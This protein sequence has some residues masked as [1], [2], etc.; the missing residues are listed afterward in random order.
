MVSDG[1]GGTDTATITIIV[2]SVSDVPEGVSDLYIMFS[3]EVLNVPAPGLLGNDS[4]GDGDSLTAGTGSNPAN[5]TATVN[6]DGSFTYTPNLDF[7]GEDTF[8]YSI[9]D[10]TG[11]QSGAFVTIQVNRPGNHQPV[12]NDDT[13]TT[14]EETPVTIDILANDSDPDGD[15]L[16]IIEIFGGG[17]VELNADNTITFYP[18]I[19]FNGTALIR[20]VVDDGNG[21][22]DR[23]DVRVTVNNV[24]DVPV[25]NG[26]AYNTGV[27]TPLSVAA[28]GVVGNDFDLENDI[29]SPVLADNVDFGALTLNSD[30]SFTYTPN[31]DFS[32]TDSFTYMANDG[33]D[34]SNEATVTINVGAG[35]NN[36][37]VANDDNYPTFVN[38]AIDLPAQG[39]ILANDAVGEPLIVSPLPAGVGEGSGVRGAS[40]PTTSRTTLTPTSIR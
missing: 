15:P 1:N 6:A 38:Q 40:S 33:S 11:E 34:N 20:Y 13:A 14:D 25:A 16:T 3:N 21:G 22:E 31:T 5:G 23:A 9:T 35:S 26:E 37:P 39:G 28:P 10:S 24:N 30:G 19:D 12:A 36:A 7:V 17:F 18:D 2:L 27:N 8:D 4:D 29:L 32:G